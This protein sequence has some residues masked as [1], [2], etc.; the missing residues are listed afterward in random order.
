MEFL[1]C[2]EN[3][4]LTQRVLG[5]LLRQWRSHLE[6][7]TVIFLNDRWLVR[8]RFDSSLEDALIKDCMAF[9]N[10]NGLRYHAPPIVSKALTDLDAGC[11][12]T[13]AMDR[14]NVVILS[15][16]IPQPEEIKHFREH[17]VAGLGYCPQSL[18]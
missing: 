11:P 10:E 8:L 3:A 1:Y 15:H 12:T 13:L 17:F 14:H 2:F 18:G 5:Y 9:L 16:G 6:L 7:T 4:S